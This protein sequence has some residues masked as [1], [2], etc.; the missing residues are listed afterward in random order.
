M[1]VI[2]RLV[3]THTFTV[4]SKYQHQQKDCVQFVMHTEDN[5]DLITFSHM[6]TVRTTTC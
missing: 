5:L 3:V 2:E 6:H 4:S 1:Q